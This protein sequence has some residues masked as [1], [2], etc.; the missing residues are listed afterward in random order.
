[1]KRYSILVLLLFSGGAYGQLKA[2]FWTYDHSSD[3]RY[4][5]RW[6]NKRLND[7]T[8]KDLSLWVEDARSH[9]DWEQLILLLE[10]KEEENLS[11]QD[12]F[13]LGAANGFR[14][15]EVLRMLSLPYVRKMKY[16]FGKAYEL[17]PKDISTLVALYKIYSDLPSFLGGSS[18]VAMGYVNQLAALEP[19]EYMLGKLYVQEAFGETIS[20]KQMS[21]LYKQVFKE[22][23]QNCSFLT[24]GL[25]AKRRNFTVDILRLF[26]VYG[27][28]GSCLEAVIDYGISSHN[29]QDSY[30]K[31]WILLYAAK[32]AWQ[33]GK[34]DFALAYVNN[35]LEYRP[36]FSE[37]QALRTE[38][39][40][41]Q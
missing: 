1:M 24:G 41:T 8:D 4:Q 20:K 30:A 40:K 10:S 37:A 23:T 22:H 29:V 26:A 31:E 38:I 28:N 19:S 9:K 14:S 18:E 27:G 3:K 5:Q 32:I 11:F 36:D 17:N 7:L 15:R 34:M 12:Y 6:N 21:A 35:A 16:F 39:L 2:P 25:Q 33:G 13:L